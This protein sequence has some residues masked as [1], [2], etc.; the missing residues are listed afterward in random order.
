MLGRDLSRDLDNYIT[1]HYGE[2]QFKRGGRVSKHFNSRHPAVA[3][4]ACPVCHVA[5][6][7]PCVRARD[8]RPREAHGTETHV[9]R[10]NKFERDA[11]P[12]EPGSVLPPS[13][14]DTD[15]DCAP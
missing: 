3:A 5:A 9:G 2:D 6:G 10:V 11:L 15:N 7:V 1:G 12:G 14:V 13:P 4:V 8:G